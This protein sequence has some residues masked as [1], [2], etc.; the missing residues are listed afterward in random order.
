LSIKLM[1][2]VW[3]ADLPQSRKFLLLSLADQAND[4][5]ECWPSFDTLSQ[6][7]SMSRRTVFDSLADLE[8]EGWLERVPRPNQKVSFRL[9]LAKLQ[10]LPLVEQ[11]GIRTGAKSAPVRNLHE[12]NERTGAKSGETGAKSALHKATPTNSNPHRGDTRTR[13]ERLEA[14]GTYDRSIVQPYLHTLPAEIDVQVFADFVKHRNVK[15]ATLSISSWLQVQKILISLQ[16]DGVDLNASLE[17]TMALGLSLPVDPRV[18]H[19][20]GAPPNRP[21]ANDDFSQVNYVGTPSDE[22]PLEL[23]P[24][25][26]AADA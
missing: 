19:R 8:Q 3:D 2:L 21:R 4:A 13:A 12:C 22:L 18:Q 1:Q 11:C 5:G 7:C 17:M 10:Q 23:R 15:R 20:G 9:D 25:T 14:M 24:P 26:A 6:R 16:A